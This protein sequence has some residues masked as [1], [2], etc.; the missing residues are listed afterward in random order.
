MAGYD[1][2]IKIKASFELEAKRFFN[3]LQKTGRKYS[4]P[5]KVKYRYMG[6]GFFYISIDGGSGGIDALFQELILNR[7]LY[8]Y[9]CTLTNKNQIISFV[10][11]PI[12]KQLIDERFSNSQ[13]RFLRKHILGKYSQNEFIPS[14]FYNPFSR[15]YEILFRKWDICII[16]DWNF[17][18]DADSFLT[19]FML[20]KIGHRGGQKSPSFSV[21]TQKVYNVGVGIGKDTKKCFNVI[22][23]ARTNGLHR[24]SNGLTHENISELA[25]QLYIYF[26]YFEE[27][28]DSQKEKTDKLHGKRYRRIKYGDE[29]WLDENGKPYCDE[30]GKPFDWKEISKKPCHDCSAIQGQYH[31]FGC[32][33]ERCPRCQGQRLGCSCKLKKDF[34]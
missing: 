23:K 17:I 19:S 7:G 33:V 4:R 26:Q 9:A 21:L 5:V 25:T 22:H 2:K 31:C 20:K 6:R 14:D 29:K 12:F 3:F 13:S 30:N 11:V 1:Q 10:I 27:F 32:D 8:Y 34:D 15:E 28:E 24:L 16:D 18:K